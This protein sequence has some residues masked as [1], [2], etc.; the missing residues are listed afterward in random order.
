ML[1]HRAVATCQ[2]RLENEAGARLEIGDVAMPAALWKTPLLSGVPRTILRRCIVRS[3]AERTS[4]L[5]PCSGLYSTPYYR[6]SC[7]LLETMAKLRQSTPYSDM[8]MMEAS[9]LGKL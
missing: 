3:D 9:G 5:H 1:L 7:P 4:A 8:C 6:I 2:F